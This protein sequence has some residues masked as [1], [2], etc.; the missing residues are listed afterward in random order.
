MTSRRPESER[1]QLLSHLVLALR[2]AGWWGLL[3]QHQ[4][5]ER[6][7][8]PWS[9]STSQHLCTRALGRKGW[10]HGAAGGMDRCSAP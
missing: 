3:Q 8:V 2:D 4:S 7:G 5:G 9:Q 6:Q 1:Q 10:G